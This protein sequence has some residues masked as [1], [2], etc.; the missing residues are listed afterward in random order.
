[1]HQ[2]LSVLLLEETSAALVSEGS[3]VAGGV[4]PW[5]FS[6]MALLEK[7]LDI[8]LDTHKREE[9]PDDLEMKCYQIL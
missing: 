9:Q 3:D 1:M 8:H 2:V 7:K 5:D 6:V 4:Q